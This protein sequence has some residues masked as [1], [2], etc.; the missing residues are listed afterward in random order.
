MDIKKLIQ[1]MADE[2]WAVNKT[3]AD[4]KVE[5]NHAHYDLLRCV[6]NDVMCGGVDVVISETWTQQM[7][8]VEVTA[9]NVKF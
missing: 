8:T 4:K 6:I 3:F 9:N 2:V 7:V 1:M 5:E